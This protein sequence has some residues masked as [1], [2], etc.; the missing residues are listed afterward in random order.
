MSSHRLIRAPGPGKFIST[1]NIGAW[2]V[3]GQEVGHVDGKPVLTKISGVIRELV[4]DGTTV[5]LGKKIGDVDPRGKI[6]HCHTI[7]DKARSLG[8]SVLEAILE[9]FNPG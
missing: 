5:V 1:A 3:Q 2:V 9:Q 6:R 8:D 7:S 4:H